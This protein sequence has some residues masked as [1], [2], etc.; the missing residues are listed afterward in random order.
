MNY[1]HQEKK[2]FR[3]F[4]I[5]Q[6]RLS[7]L[8]LTKQINKVILKGNE[9]KIRQLVKCTLLPSRVFS[10]RSAPVYDNIPT[11]TCPASPLETTTLCDL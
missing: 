10:A 1:C 7:L 6:K 8:Q 9:E 2:E 5:A 3:G 11:A 4:H